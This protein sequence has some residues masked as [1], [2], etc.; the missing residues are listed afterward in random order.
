[1]VVNF[2]GKDLNAAGLRVS[3][4][5]I[6][7][8]P[9]EINQA[10]D[11]ISANVTAAN[12]SALTGGEETDLHSHAASGGGSGAQ[13]AT[14]TLSTAQLL[15]LHTTPVTLVAAVPGS[16]LAPIAL[17]LRST[18][19]SIAFDGEGSGNALRVKAG[20]ILWFAAT[21][22]QV[23]RGNNGEGGFFY[24]SGENIALADQDTEFVGLPLTVRIDSA[25]SNGNGSLVVT[26][27]YATVSP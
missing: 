23:F 6:T 26:V 18:E 20:N 9:D 12:L 14:I 15:A 7:A 21:L 13:V 11:G 17:M 24:S 25:L 5:K 22:T 4:T 27:A 16:V 3:N 10:L 1:M 8:T 19:G 2:R